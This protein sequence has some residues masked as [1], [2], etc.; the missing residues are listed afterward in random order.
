MVIRASP[1]SPSI[2]GGWTAQPDLRA[3]PNAYWNR[4]VEC[5]PGWQHDASRAAQP[6]R[7][8]RHG[9]GRR[10]ILAALG[11]RAGYGIVALLVLNS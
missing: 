7:L 3:H 2:G 4:D 10:Q 8:Q 5:S 1:G 9:G 11:L 6:R